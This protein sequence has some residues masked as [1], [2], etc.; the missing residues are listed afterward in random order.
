M[1]LLLL[2]GEYC[3]PLQPHLHEVDVLAFVRDLDAEFAAQ[4]PSATRALPH[5]LW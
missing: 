3:S 2:P 5:T 1:A 4:P